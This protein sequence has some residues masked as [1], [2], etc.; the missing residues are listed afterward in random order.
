LSGITLNRILHLRRVKN[1]V[2][3]KPLS[4]SLEEPGELAFSKGCEIK[5]LNGPN[6]KQFHN[7]YVSYVKGIPEAHRVVIGTFKCK[8]RV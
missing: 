4:R 7:H 3:S 1:L 6:L 8:I 5:V 2:R